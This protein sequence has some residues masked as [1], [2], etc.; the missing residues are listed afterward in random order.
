MFLDLLRKARERI[1]TRQFLLLYD[2]NNCDLKSKYIKAQEEVL[3][4]AE[5]CA[6][7]TS[8][9]AKRYAIGVA[10]KTSKKPNITKIF[11]N[12]AQS[13]KWLSDKRKTINTGLIKKENSS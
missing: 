5:F 6:I 2:L 9:V 1:G 7:L 4:G 12:R 10:L 8:N 3:D 13:I 11:A